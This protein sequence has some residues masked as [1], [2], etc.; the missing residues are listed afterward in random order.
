MLRTNRAS[1]LFCINIKN[2]LSAMH[3]AKGIL[4]KNEWVYN[5]SKV[6]TLHVYRT[7]LNFA[8]LH[9]ELECVELFYA[10]SIQLKLLENILT[11]LR[12]T[13]HIILKI[14]H[15]I[16]LYALLIIAALYFV[17]MF[18]SIIFMGTS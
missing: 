7:Y 4:R 12:S 11:I 16:L 9:E 8:S 17:T 1:Q 2:Y 15:R 18:A 3:I 6:K 14:L 10:L 5:V 13:L